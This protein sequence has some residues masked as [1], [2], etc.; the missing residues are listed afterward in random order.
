MEPNQIW[1][2]RWASDSSPI[3]K[4]Y[5]EIVCR[6]KSAVCLAAD[7]YKM[8]DLFRLLKE[9]GPYIAAL[10]THVD[11]ILDWDKDTWKLFCHEAGEL[12]LLIFEDRKFADIGKISKKQMGGIY[13]IQS[14]SD[15]VTA[16]LISGSDII[17]GIQSAWKESARV[18][19]VLLLA[20]IVE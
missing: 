2:K 11:L 18:G 16:H 20:Q 3:L 15:L 9:V 13:D 6:K 5:M 1:K 7:R 14:W 4:K 10:K 17:T 19:G 12:D 8:D